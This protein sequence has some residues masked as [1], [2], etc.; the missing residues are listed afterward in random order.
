MPLS[1]PARE[2]QQ[3]RGIATSYLK[4]VADGEERWE[5]RAQQIQNGELP[6][7]W[8]VLDERGYIK[9]VAGYETAVTLMS[10]RNDLFLLLC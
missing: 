3:T 6:H 10:G 8:D 2:L 9:D 5:K 4:K 1:W 7:V